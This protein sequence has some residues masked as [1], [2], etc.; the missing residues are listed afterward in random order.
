MPVKH[1]V[2]QID[3][4]D[5]R[6]KRYVSAYAKYDGMLQKAPGLWTQ[7]GQAAGAQLTVVRMISAAMLAQAD[8]LKNVSAQTT[9]VTNKSRLMVD[10]WKKIASSTR[11]VENHLKSAFT[12]AARFTGISTVIGG[13]GLGAG[14]FGL[15]RLAMIA[16]A[17]RRS[18]TGLGLSYGQQSAFGLSY[19]RLIDSGSFL[20]GVSTGR[21]NITSGA[22]IALQTL[23]LSPTTPGSTGDLAN[24]G[25]KRIR[26]IA[27][28]TPEEQL[29]VLGQTRRL[30]ELGLSVEDLRRLKTMSDQEFGEFRGQYAKRSKDLEVG[31]KSLKVM[32]DFDNALETLTKTVTTGLIAGFS[33][34]APSLTTLTNA[35]GEATQSFLSSEGFKWVIDQVASGLQS[36]AKYV[37]SD[38]F[39]DDVKAFTDAIGMLARKTVAALRWLGLIPDAANIAR[40]PTTTQGMA[41]DVN[42][43]LLHHHGPGLWSQIKGFFSGNTADSMAGVPPNGLSSMGGVPQSLP[44]GTPATGEM[45]MYRRA[46]SGI[47]SGSAAGRYNAE[48]PVT[49][50]GDHAYG[51][52]QVMGANIPSWTQR[53]LGHSMSPAEFLA[54]PAAQDKVFDFIF[55]E[56]VK[57][58]GKE[59]AARAWYGGES[60]MNNLGATD[61]TPGRRGPTVLQ[62]GQQFL[63]NIPG[64]TSPATVKVDVNNNTG[65][66]AAVVVSQMGVI[67][68]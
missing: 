54:D 23:G 39:K 14:V 7:T 52:Y 48:G 9:D 45:D 24:E 28:D 4:D 55:G 21:G 1:S 6:F 33:K 36:F 32:Q 31:D 18:S 12:T 19:N 51:R 53:A 20:G 64:A 27:K 25:L 3:V 59:R 68:R 65:G 46:I 43:R 5:T 34:L 29:G 41:D 38:A 67:P 35:L 16:S 40:P 8:V 37:S 11:N 56:Y 42:N 47:E 62:Y 15:D 63:N 44:G 60:G 10:F 2:I 58:Y 30:D 50:S 49:H 26:D 22:A 61:S 13:L 57:K 17:G 66:N